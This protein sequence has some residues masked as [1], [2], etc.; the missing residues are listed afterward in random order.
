[1]KS[2]LSLALLVVASVF[3]SPL[4][5][6][7]EGDDQAAT[8][9]DTYGMDNFDRLD[10]LKF[11]CNVRQG[12]TTESR[13][14]TWD[15]AG[16]KVTLDTRQAGKPFHH[17]YDDVDRRFEG[18]ADWLLFPLRF[19]EDRPME[20]SLDEEQ[21]LPIPPGTAD[22][23]TIAYGGDDSR[24]GDTDEIYVDDD[25]GLI[26]QRVYR[27]GGAAVPTVVA[28][29][30]DQERLGPIVVALRHKSRDGRTEIWFT[31]VEAKLQGSTAW[32]HPTPR[33]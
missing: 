21:P 13:A 25:S 9:A 22:E 30:E 33:S 3:V 12:S 16:H 14:W 24:A 5:A 27:K 17:V 29:W 1:M 15:I 18:D 31:N 4:R 26:R 2:Q 28:T 11:T 23:L 19:T 7:E 6:D 10:A 20:I 32:V 8:I